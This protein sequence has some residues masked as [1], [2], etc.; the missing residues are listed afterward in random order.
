MRI[1]IAIMFGLYLASPAHAQD[2]I[3]DV[4]REID[5]LQE[6]ERERLRESERQFEQSQIAPPAGAADDVEEDAAADRAPCRAVTRVDIIG[7]TL[8]DPRLFLKDTADLIGPCISANAVTELRRKITNTYIRDGYITSR[9]F[10]LPK[11][12]ALDVLTI[13]VVE[14]RVSAIV[15][16][17]Q[18][19][20]PYTAGEVALTFPGITGKPLNLRD[21]E[22]GVDHLLTAYNLKVSD[23]HTYFVTGDAQAEPVWV[24]NNC[25]TPRYPTSY[26]GENLYFGT[27]PNSQ[28]HTERHLIENNIDVPS[29][30]NAIRADLNSRPQMRVGE[31]RRKAIT[32]N[33]KT[34]EYAVKRLPDGRINVSRVV[35]PR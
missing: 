35:V 11:P 7:M 25:A 31:Y 21:L 28:F 10:V 27:S 20:R 22:Q 3:R 29:A 17:G 18:T 26:P 34:I 30:Y 1:C 14:G 4:Q 9:A 32:V 15:S 16:V 33:G 8:Y 23:F 12:D 19:G 6:R 5:R 13:Q 24:H 2:T